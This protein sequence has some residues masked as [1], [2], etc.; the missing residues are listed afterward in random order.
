MDKK[1]FERLV[2]FLYLTMRNDLPTGVVCNTVNAVTENTEI[3]FRFSNVHLEAL[4]RD[5]A[6][7]ICE[8]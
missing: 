1:V 4:A 5:Y 6:T 8:G 3:D 7:R 2:A